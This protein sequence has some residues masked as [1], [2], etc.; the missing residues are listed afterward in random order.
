[1][2]CDRCIRM[3]ARLEAKPTLGGLVLGTMF[4]G[5]PIQLVQWCNYHLNLGAEQ[6]YV[7]LDRPDAALV[8]ALPESSR[9]RW[10]VIDESTWDVFYAANSSNVE[11]RQVDA[12]RW[13]ARLAQSD[14]HRYLAFVDTDELLDFDVAFADIAARHPD[15]AALT[16]PV[17]EMWF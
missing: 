17:R 10:E 4:R 7:V 14:G 11:R 13:L 12:I 5:D 16:V 15:A 1:G 9:I 3:S 2:R 6:L 8:D